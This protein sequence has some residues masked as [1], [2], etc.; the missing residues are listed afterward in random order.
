MSSNK[1]HIVVKE[2]IAIIVWIIAIL[3]EKEMVYALFANKCA[4]VQDVRSKVF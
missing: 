4:I 1:E 3:T 2:N